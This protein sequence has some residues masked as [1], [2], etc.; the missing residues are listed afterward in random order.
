MIVM[1][2]STSEVSIAI[3]LLEIITLTPLTFSGVS[4]ANLEQISGY[5]ESFS[6]SNRVSYSAVNTLGSVFVPPRFVD[7]A[8]SAC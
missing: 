2:S 5:C 1:I 4:S 6:F 7:A 3:L 8:H